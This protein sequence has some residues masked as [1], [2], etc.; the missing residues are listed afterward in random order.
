MVNKD[1]YI[2][3]VQ[4]RRC[5]SSYRSLQCSVTLWRRIM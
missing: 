4:G 3:K 2:W 1:E 5:R